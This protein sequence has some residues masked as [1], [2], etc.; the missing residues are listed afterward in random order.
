MANARERY[1]RK[2]KVVTFR[3]SLEVFR[4]LEEIKAKGGLSYA[5]LVKAGA[6]I[7]G[8]EVMGKLGRVSGL[9]SRLAA[10]V[11][12][13][14]EKEEELGKFIDEERARR[15]RQ[16]DSEMAAFKL[17]DRRW[18]TEQV[19]FKLGI[20]RREAL[21]YFRQWAEE[22]RDS[23][24]IKREML[25]QC[26]KEH[27][28]KLKNDRSW[29]RLWPSTPQEAVDEMDRQIEHYQRLLGAPSKL[30]KA[31]RQYLLAQYS[32][33]VMPGKGAAPQKR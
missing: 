23:R 12:A 22:H 13:V 11:S 26:L 25:R 2:T 15:L 16:L 4:E 9:E 29:A 5:D 28:R 30:S 21:R 7:A 10:L 18:T 19:R 14:K 32:A 33:T 3:V 8:E 17:F 24:A 31:E 27:V 6:G 20:S 1:D